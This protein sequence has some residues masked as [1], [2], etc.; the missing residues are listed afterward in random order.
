ML[1]DFT[2]LNSSTLTQIKYKAYV[3]ENRAKYLLTLHLQKTNRSENALLL[4]VYQSC[5]ETPAVVLRRVLSLK[6]QITIT[7][8]FVRVHVYF[9]HDDVKFLPA[10]SKKPNISCLCDNVNQSM[11]A[12]LSGE[13]SRSPLRWVFA[14]PLK[15]TADRS[16]HFRSPLTYNFIP[17]R[18][19]RSTLAHI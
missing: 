15:V 12:E 19:N 16:A 7:Q 18:W 8:C 13:N 10:V 1:Q 17:L 3:S 9:C 4:P 11:W 6:L 2:W 14:P 5:W